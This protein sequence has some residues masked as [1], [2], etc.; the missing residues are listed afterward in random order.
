MPVALLRIKARS[1]YGNL[2]F[3]A[4]R[5]NLDVIFFQLQGTIQSYEALVIQNLHTS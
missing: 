3:D 5:F 4:P 2:L 1:N